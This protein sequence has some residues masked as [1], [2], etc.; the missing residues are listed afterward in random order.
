P[1]GRPYC[2]LVAEEDE[3]LRRLAAAYLEQAGYSPLLAGDL[4]EVEEAFRRDSSAID[5][6]ILDHTLLS[7]SAAES[8]RQFRHASP[9]L[10]I[11]VAG[12]GSRPGGLADVAGFI[13]RPYQSGELW[14]AVALALQQK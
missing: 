4:L 2:V 12:A 6:L 14:T 5:L 3:T 13:N 11:I 9:A 8:I 1:R 7:P 10:K